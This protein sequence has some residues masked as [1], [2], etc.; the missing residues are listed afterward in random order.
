MTAHLRPLPPATPADAIA[1]VVRDKVI[2]GEHTFLI[3]KPGGSDDLLAH[4]AVRAAFAADEYLPYWADLWPAARMLAKAVLAEPWAAGLTVL[5]VGCGLGLPGIAALARGLHVIFSDYD[6][7]AVRFAADNARLNGFA[8]FATATI[9]LRSPPPGLSV[10]VL[11]GADLLYEP[12]MVEPVVAFVDSVLA[13]GGVA[14][15]ADPDRISARPFKWL[16]Q[17]AGL[18]V[19]AVFARAGQP[20]GERTKGTV[21]RITRG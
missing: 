1:E 9:D 21:Y 8:D 5:E 3:D 2:L 12:R 7:T 14:L 19:E 18:H 17:N 11:L 16:C 4:P 20:G 10:P 15:I 13:P 6:A